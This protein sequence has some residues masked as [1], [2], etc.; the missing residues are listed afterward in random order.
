ME[1]YLLQLSD[2]KEELGDSSL[3]AYLKQLAPP[4]VDLEF[5]SLC[6]N[7]EDADGVAL[8]QKLIRWTMRQIE[9]GRDYELLQA[10]LHRFLTIYS[11]LISSQPQL[12]ADITALKRAQFD[13][14]VKFRHLLQ[15]N[16]CLLKMT[17][18]IPIT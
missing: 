3:L 18:N 13:A 4:A 10:Y 5:R 16:L 8:L 14:N 1:A 6:L 12:A 15:K 17:G 11:E 9:T 7:E 2:E